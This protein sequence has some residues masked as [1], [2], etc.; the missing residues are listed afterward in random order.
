MRIS[1]PSRALVLLL[2]VALVLSLALHLSGS[3]LQ[4]A[5]IVPILTAFAFP[6]VRARISRALPITLQSASLLSLD[7]PRAP[8]LN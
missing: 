8:P 7:A 1:P 6:S 5:L 4:W 2:C 3:Q